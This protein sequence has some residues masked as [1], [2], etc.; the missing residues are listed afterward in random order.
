[1]FSFPQVANFAFRFGRR[2]K[3]QIVCFVLTCDSITDAGL[4]QAQFCMVFRGIRE[5]VREGMSGHI[6][7]PNPPGHPRAR[8]R[9]SARASATL[10][11]LMRRLASLTRFRKPGE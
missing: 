3:P 7:S 1:M 11:S 2:P 8:A 4:V 10:T 5:R 9:G 6:M